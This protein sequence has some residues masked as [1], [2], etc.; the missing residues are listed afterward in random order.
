MRIIPWRRC[1][2]LRAPVELPSARAGQKVL[3]LQTLTGWDEKLTHGRCADAQG[4]SVHAAL[5]C[6]ADQHKQIARARSSSCS[7]H[8]P[9]ADNGEAVVKGKGYADASALH[10]GKAGRIDGG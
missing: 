1:N 3:S 8:E 6:G 5:R 2:R 7:C 10:F 4:F 9:V